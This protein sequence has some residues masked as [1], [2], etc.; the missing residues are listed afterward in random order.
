MQ[1][2]SGVWVREEVSEI[3]CN[4]ASIIPKG[5]RT[6]AENKYSDL[7]LLCF[8]VTGFGALLILSSLG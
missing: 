5:I 2:G 6:I 8:V 1:R 3:A 7:I 4:G